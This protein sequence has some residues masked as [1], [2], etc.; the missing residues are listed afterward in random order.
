MPLKFTPW[1]KLIGE[2]PEQ[3][4]RQPFIL[5]ITRNG[6]ER[7]MPLAAWGCG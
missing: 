4:E 6:V 5:M 3:F 2:T 1:D 7:V